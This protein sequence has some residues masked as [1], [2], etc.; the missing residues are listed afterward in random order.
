[1]LILHIHLQIFLDVKCT[2]ADYWT[3]KAANPDKFGEME[4]ELYRKIEI[5][6]RDLLHELKRN[7]KIETIYLATEYDRLRSVIE[8]YDIASA[9]HNFMLGTAKAP[10]IPGKFLDANKEFGLNEGM[11]VGMYL[12][13]ALYADLLS[14]ELFK[15]LILFHLKNVDHDVSKFSKTIQ[16]SA[17]RAWLHLKPY[18]DNAFRNAIA[19]C[20]I[21]VR[22]KKVVIYRDA[23]LIPIDEMEI[24]QFMIRLKRANVL[25]ICAF[26]LLAELKRKDWFK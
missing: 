26:N 4:K 12:Q 11:A 24:D 6:I 18:V 5:V 10:D 16:E 9:I 19:H 3:D 22:A 8:R 14:I 23:K 21:A 7:N 17:P 1:M 15:L 25:F 20:T 13:A 2:L